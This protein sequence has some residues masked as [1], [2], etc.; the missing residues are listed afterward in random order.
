[1]L[2]I[3]SISIGRD[4]KQPWRAIAGHQN[5]EFPCSKSGGQVSGA[6]WSIGQKR[7]SI[8]RSFDLGGDWMLDECSLYIVHEAASAPLTIKCMDA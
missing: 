8:A 7:G 2:G 4:L 5:G 3:E 6:V 1:L